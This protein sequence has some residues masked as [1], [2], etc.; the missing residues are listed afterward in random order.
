[1]AL[2]QDMPDGNYA[3]LH[4]AG[5][6][7]KVNVWRTWK[8]AIGNY[9][10]ASCNA[11]ANATGSVSRRAGS[12]CSCMCQ[13]QATSDDQSYMSSEMLSI[14]DLKT[15]NTVMTCH[16][17]FFLHSCLIC[18]FALLHNQFCTPPLL[19]HLPQRASL[20][21]CLCLPSCRTWVMTLTYGY[22]FG[23]ELT[24]DNVLPQYM[25][26][27]F[28]LDLHIAGLLAA[29]FGMMNLFSRPSGGVISDLAARKFGMRGRLWAM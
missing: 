4:K 10:Y 11:L 29:I 18:H 24:V 6:M 17:I 23:V 12:A 22:C 7:R 2:A 19:S 25:Y 28:H 20:C 15:S 13:S 1:M 27:Q 8:A 16:G 14:C 5:A 21:A 26:D 9:R 3:A